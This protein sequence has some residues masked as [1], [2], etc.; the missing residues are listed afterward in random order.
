[1]IPKK[2]H[3]CWFGGNEKNDLI[4]KCI[5]SWKKFCPD[6]EIIEWNENNFDININAYVKE[7][8][9]EKR[10]A[11][12]SDYVRLWSVYN[13]GGIYLDTDVELI[14]N[15]DHVFENKC[16]FCYEDDVFIATG[17]GFGAEAQNPLVKE[18]LDDYNE[19]HFRLPNGKLDLTPCPQRNTNTIKGSKIS[20]YYVYPKEYFCPLDYETKQLTLTENTVAIHW[21]GE[22]WMT[23]S[24]KKKNQFKKII[25][26]LLC[27]RK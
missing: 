7:A 22:S 11:F 6:C 13:F 10:W 1:M 2:I 5:N 21:F 23:K 8:Y 3:Y 4:I 19:I 24:E 15:I 20:D 9:E 12:V 18:V 27:V 14:K 17:L 25:K 16:F 26:R